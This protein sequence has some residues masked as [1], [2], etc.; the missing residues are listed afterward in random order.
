MR[1]RFTP[2]SGGLVRGLAPFAAFVF[3]FFLSPLRSQ[4]HLGRTPHPL[5]KAQLF[6]AVAKQLWRRLE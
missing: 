4:K 5:P 6:L 1:E 2:L 3:I